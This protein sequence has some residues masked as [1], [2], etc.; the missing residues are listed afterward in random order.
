MISPRREVE[1][2]QIV[3]HAALFAGPGL[4]LQP[5]DQV[6]DIENGGASA[7]GPS[8]APTPRVPPRMRARATLMARWVLPVP[9]PPI[10]TTLR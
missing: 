6:D 9:V 3:G 1:A 10:R 4:G 2:G 7:I 8:A 5:V